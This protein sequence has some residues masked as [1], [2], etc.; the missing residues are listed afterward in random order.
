MRSVHLPNIHF[1]S[2]YSE[3]LL[4]AREIGQYRDAAPTSVTV[5][6]SDSRTMICLDAVVWGDFPATP[7]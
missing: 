7:G 1:W 3:T 6:F 4:G 2:T 5:T